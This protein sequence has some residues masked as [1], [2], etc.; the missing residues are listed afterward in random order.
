MKKLLLSLFSVTLFFSCVTNNTNSSAPSAED[1]AIFNKHVESWK[2]VA[3]G[4]AAEDPDQV[5]SI[6]ADS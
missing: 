1:T 6:F 5:M 2:L 4:F 3:S